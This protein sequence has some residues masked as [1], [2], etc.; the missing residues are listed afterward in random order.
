V[1]YVQPQTWKN[2]QTGY[3][4]FKRVVLVEARCSRAFSARTE[5]GQPAYIASATRDF[6][7]RVEKVVN[8]ADSHQFLCRSAHSSLIL[9]ALN[10]PP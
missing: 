3:I 7:K 1:L 5:N 8:L 4:E 2:S 10:D 9:R 6:G